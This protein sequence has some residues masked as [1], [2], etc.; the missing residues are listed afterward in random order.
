[1]QTG[2]GADQGSD[3]NLGLMEECSGNNN[4][5]NKR[6]KKANEKVSQEVWIIMTFT[7]NTTMLSLHTYN[8]LACLSMCVQSCTPLRVQWS[9][10]TEHSKRDPHSV[11]RCFLLGWS[12]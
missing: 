9:C 1:M 2:L 7:L 10:C 11:F 5:E 12:D 8:G 4:K 3:L 6:S